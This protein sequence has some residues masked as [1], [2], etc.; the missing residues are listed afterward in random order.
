[1][2]VPILGAGKVRQEESHL[3]WVCGRHGRELRS[4]LAPGLQTQHEVPRLTQLNPFPQQEGQKRLLPVP[5]GV[6]CLMTGQ[7]NIILKPHYFSAM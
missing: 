6:S 1:M 5:V 3:L 7:E 4:L 2:Q